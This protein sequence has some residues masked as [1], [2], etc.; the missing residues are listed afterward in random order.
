MV[1]YADFN[2]LKFPDKEQ[3]KEKIALFTKQGFGNLPVCMAKTQYSFSTDPTL[4]NAPVD[5]DIEIRELRLSAGAGFI[6]P[7]DSHRYLSSFRGATQHSRVGF[8]QVDQQTQVGQGQG[9]PDVTG[10]TVLG[11]GLPQHI[12]SSN[13]NV[14]VLKE[15]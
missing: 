7:N 14:R 9:A 6:V 8:E 1:P 4:K 15:A 3:A 13:P 12:T 11:S 2:L 10:T 5:H